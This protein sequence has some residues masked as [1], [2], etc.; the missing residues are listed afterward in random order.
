MAKSADIVEDAKVVAGALP[1]AA[2]PADMAEDDNYIVFAQPYVF[3]DETYTGVDLSGMENLCARDMI[4]VQRKLE[5]TGSVSVLPEMSMEY[6]LLFAA[7]GSKLP[8]EFFE[9]LPPKE[10]VKVKNRVQAFFYGAD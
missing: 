10:A 5:R 3:E 7:K 8:V 4:T 9:G 2:A 1:E 6:A